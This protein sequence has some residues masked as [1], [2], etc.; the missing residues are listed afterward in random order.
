VD[1]VTEQSE[2][3]TGLA[4]QVSAPTNNSKK[5]VTATSACT[6]IKPLGSSCVTGV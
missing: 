4:S 1:G 6:I 2:Q 5:P 3:R